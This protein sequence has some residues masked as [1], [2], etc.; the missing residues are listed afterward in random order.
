[1]MSEYLSSG[2]EKP[3]R[4][5]KPRKAM[6]QSSAKQDERT[7]FLH[8][9]KAERMRVQLCYQQFNWC[10]TCKGQWKDPAEAWEALTVSHIEPRNDTSTRYERRREPDFRGDDPANILIECVACNM[11]REPQPEFSK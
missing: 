9:I 5:R 7:A 10:Q 6:K 8:G 1:M 4:D 11:H 2:G 3:K